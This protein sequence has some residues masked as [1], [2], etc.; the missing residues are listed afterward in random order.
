[1]NL[2][3][4]ARQKADSFE[5]DIKFV[6]TQAEEAKTKIEEVVDE[7]KEATEELHRIKVDRSL[8]NEP[9]FLKEV[10]NFPGAEYTFS[11][12]SQD[13]ESVKL[14]LRIDEVL[15]RAGWVR[16]KP[17]GVVMGLPVFAKEPDFIVAVTTGTGVFVS[18]ESLESPESINLRPR[19]KWTRPVQAAM[20][21]AEALN[22]WISPKQD[23]KTLTVNRGTSDIVQITVGKK[24]IR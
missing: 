22:L 13:E 18:I 15:Q 5:A 3:T 10:S 7:A 21:L 23:A 16:V 1:M 2:A 19:M 20:G 14:L 24:P 6:K 9:L 8:T 12:V 4:G 11:G 17:N